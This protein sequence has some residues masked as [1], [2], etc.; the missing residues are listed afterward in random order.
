M[1]GNEV[2]VEAKEDFSEM[3]DGLSKSQTRDMFRCFT[4]P[5]GTSAADVTT[6]L[7]PEGELTLSIK[8]TK[9]VQIP[10]GQGEE[11]KVNE[12]EGK[13]KEMPSTGQIGENQM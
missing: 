3:K 10:L 6:A 4:V 9:P 7:S 11:I 1:I 2:R 12:I 8:R 13:P 5:R